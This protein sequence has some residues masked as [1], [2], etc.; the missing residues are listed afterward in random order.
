VLGDIGRPFVVIMI[1][2]GHAESPFGSRSTSEPCRGSLRHWETDA[3]GSGRTSPRPL[4]IRPA[5]RYGNLLRRC[6]G[7][8]LRPRACVAL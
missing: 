6:D 3:L 4:A 7:C 2:L 1:G 5:R 8:R